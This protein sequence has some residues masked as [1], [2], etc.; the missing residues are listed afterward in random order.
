MTALPRSASIRFRGRSGARTSANANGAPSQ[1]DYSDGGDAWNYFTHDQARSRPTAG[2]KTASRGVSDDQQ[3]LLLRPGFV[4]RQRSDPQGAPVRPH[5]QRDPYLAFTGHVPFTS[6]GYEVNATFANSANIALNSPVRIA[7]VEVGKVDLDQPRRRRDQGH[8]H[9]R[10]SRPADPRRRLR[11]DP[12][13]DLPRGQLLRRTR[14]R[15]PQRA[16][17][18]QRRHDPGQPH[19]DRGPARRSLDRAAVARPRRP[20]PVCSRATARR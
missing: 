6:Y 14:S 8:L 10:R 19:L 15:Q 1:E 4:E 2:A 17:D 7:G 5:E 16:G 9:R 3:R 20:Q 11:R 18:G 12:A 13:A